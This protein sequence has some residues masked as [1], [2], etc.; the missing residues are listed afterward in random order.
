MYSMIVGFDMED[1]RWSYCN[2]CNF[3]GWKYQAVMAS[4]KTKKQ[5]ELYVIII[6]TMLFGTPSSTS[7]SA[8][9][10]SSASSSLASSYS[11][12]SYSASF[13]LPSSCSALS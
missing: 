1:W 3:I 10:S 11:A 5:T 4:V 7:F 13:Y 6:L 12:S 2:Y 8:F 9:S